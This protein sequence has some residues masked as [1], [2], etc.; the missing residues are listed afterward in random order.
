MTETEI[1][2]AIFGVLGMLIVTFWALNGYANRWRDIGIGVERRR[3]IIA[4]DE[5]GFITIGDECFR[6]ERDRTL[7]EMDLENRSEGTDDSGLLKRSAPYLDDSG[8]LDRL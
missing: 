5:C 8:I 7:D 2:T 1:F 4:A 6:V 3:W